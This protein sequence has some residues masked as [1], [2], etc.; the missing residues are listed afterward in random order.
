MPSME[1]PPFAV[2][3]RFCI[4]YPGPGPLTPGTLMREFRVTYSRAASLLEELA[5]DRV[6]RAV[7]YGGFTARE[8]TPPAVRA[9]TRHYQRASEQC[10]VCGWSVPPALR[11]RPRNTGCQQRHVIPVACGGDSDPSNLVLL[12]PNHHRLAHMLYTMVGRDHRG[13]LTREELLRALR[14]ADTD[15]DS[16][17]LD[18]ARAAMSKVARL[19]S[20]AGLPAVAPAPDIVR[21]RKAAA[22]PAAQHPTALIPHPSTAQ[23]KVHVSERHKGSVFR[24]AK[25]AM[26]AANGS[27]NPA[28]DT[29]DTPDTA[30]GAR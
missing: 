22:R 6:L 23:I 13:P 29:P 30:T 14:L 7:G 2:V 21:L 5:R 18:R 15:P 27:G 9:A 1:E 19:D 11:I 3:R 17:R 25:C 24:C 16:F 10:E 12:C 8:E 28:A 4:Q 26:L 20:G